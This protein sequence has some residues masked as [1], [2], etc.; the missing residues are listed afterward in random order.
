MHSRQQRQ[1]HEHRIT[2]QGAK[3]DCTAHPHA[4]GH[5]RYG[6][7]PDPR[8][9]TVPAAAAKVLTNAMVGSRSVTVRTCERRRCY[10]RRWRTRRRGWD[11]GERDGRR[12][13]GND[14]VRRGRVREGGGHTTAARSERR[15]AAPS[16]ALS[17]ATAAGDQRGCPERRERLAAARG[18]TSERSSLP[19]GAPV[20]VQQARVRRERRLR[21]GSV[22][23]NADHAP[24]MNRLHKPARPPDCAPSRLVLKSAREV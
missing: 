10:A 7:V 5:T 1:R 11:D 3:R 14:T 15:A 23:L 4:A 8:A 18:W 2:R 13:A 20:G 24:S 19:G 21:G 6:Y 22:E 12:C 9:A 17:R 16:G